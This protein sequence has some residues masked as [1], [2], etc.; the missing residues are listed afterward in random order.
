M[1]KRIA[2]LLLLGSCFLLLKQVFAKSFNEDICFPE[3]RIKKSMINS[4]MALIDSIK[5]LT[6]KEGKTFYFLNPMANFFYGNGYSANISNVEEKTLKEISRIIYYG[7]GYKEQSS[8]EYYVATQYLLFKAYKE[9]TIAFLDKGSNQVFPFQNEIAQ[10]EK[11]LEKNE[12]QFEDFTTTKKFFEVEDEYI[13]KHFHIQG[14]NI[15]AEEKKD[16]IGITLLKDKEDYTIEFIPKVD[17][18]NVEVYG[19]NGATQFIHMD[20]I[21]ENTYSRTIHVKQEE[22]EN[23][24]IEQS[25]EVKDESSLN[26][27]KKKEKEN[28]VHVPATGKHSYTWIILLFL[29][30]DA[31]YVFKK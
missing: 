6:D 21:C 29:L 17:C 4:S 15:K 14:E 28:T 3:Y 31:Y 16:K 12:F 11:N 1:K 30:G 24:K 22:K 19:R 5:C 10:I 13:L 9:Y 25:E 7:Y 27:K 18:S 23:I 8:L 26:I 20:L 2:V